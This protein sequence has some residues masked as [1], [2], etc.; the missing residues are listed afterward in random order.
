MRFFSLA[1]T[2]E[3]LREAKR[4]ILDGAGLMQ[5]VRETQLPENY[6]RVLLGIVSCPAIAH[7]FEIASKFDRPFAMNG[8]ARVL[9]ENDHV[10]Y[11]RVV[12]DDF[13]EPRVYFVTVPRIRCIEE[14]AA[15]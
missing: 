15:Q 1:Y 5:V 2:G 14:R 11:R 8:T 4:L 7:T 13:D 12:V 9:N 10:A 3:Q 6:V